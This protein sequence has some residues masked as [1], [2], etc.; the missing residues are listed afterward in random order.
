MAVLQLDHGVEDAGVRKDL[1]ASLT[2]LLNIVKKQKDNADNLF[3]VE[4]VQNLDSALN[5]V[6]VIVFKALEGEGVE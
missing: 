4:V 2:C 3:L 1:M 5:N 6:E